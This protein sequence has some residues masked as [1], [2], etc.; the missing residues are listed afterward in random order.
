MSVILPYAPGSSTDVVVRIL[1]DGSAE[2][3]GGT[4]LSEYKPGATM[5]LA[6][7]HVARS[8]PD[9]S[10]LLLGTIATFMQAPF[11]LHNIGFDPKA[12]FAHI[13]LLAESLYLLVANPR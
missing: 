12:D 2:Q 1:T 9:G 8:R 7:P 11:V 5:M 10:T 13:S 6:A 4:S 3:L